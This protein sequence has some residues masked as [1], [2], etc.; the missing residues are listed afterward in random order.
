MEYI[1][2]EDAALEEHIEEAA[3]FHCNH[4]PYSI[5]LI[6]LEFCVSHAADPNI[7]LW[8]EYLLMECC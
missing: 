7:M 2:H 6:I 8:W 3:G 4:S 5:V 1:K